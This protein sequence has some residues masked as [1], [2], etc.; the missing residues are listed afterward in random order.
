MPGHRQI[1]VDDLRPQYSQSS[2]RPV[3]LGTLLQW[4]LRVLLIVFIATTLLAEPPRRNGVVCLILL[5]AYVVTV[6]CWSFW[7]LWPAHRSAIATKERVTLLVLGGDREGRHQDHEHPDAGPAHHAKG[8]Q[9]TVGRLYAAP[10]PGLQPP[11]PWAFCF[12]PARPSP[13]GN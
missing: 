9:P 2:D 4:S 8:A 7:A 10:C 13:G 1:A 11:F 5:A 3:F 12:S 6:G